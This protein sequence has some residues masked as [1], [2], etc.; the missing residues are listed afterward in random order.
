MGVTLVTGAGRRLGSELALAFARAGDAVAVH[1]RSARKGAEEAVGRARA[2]GVEAE[3]FAADLSLPDAPRR[4]VEAALLRFGR[5]DTLV[6]SASPWLEKPVAEVT[7]ADWDD[8]FAVGPRAAFLLAQAAAPALEASSGAIL[9][10]SDVAA[11][12]AWP[13]H[14]PHAVAKAAV[15]ALVVN[16][17]AAL[18]PGVRVNGLAPGIVL[19]PADLPAE[20]VERLVARTPLRRPVEVADLVAM[21]VA[22]C[23][24]RS[25]TGQVVAVDAG[26]SIV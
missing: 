22:L 26:R 12:R 16:L 9:L 19:P 11:T 24:N 5:L 4:L 10:V 15:N 6:H 21:A 13:R 20:E 18:A 7:A 8:V 3:A 2:A 17:A 14:L 1:Y 23:R 25:T